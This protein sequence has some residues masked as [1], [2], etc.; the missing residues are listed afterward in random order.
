MFTPINNTKELNKDMFLKHK[1]QTSC[2]ILDQ[3]H[4]IL[5]VMLKNIMLIVILM[6]FIN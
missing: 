4:I 1:I 5:F 6:F 3:Y 2:Q